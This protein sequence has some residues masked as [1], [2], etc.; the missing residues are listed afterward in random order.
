MLGIAEATEKLLNWPKISV[1]ADLCRSGE[2]SDRIDFEVC[3]LLGRSFGALL[4]R[5]WI[6][7]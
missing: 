1:D 4:A 6:K 3:W 5:S 2:F 7:Q